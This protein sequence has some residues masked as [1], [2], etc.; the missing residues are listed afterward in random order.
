MQQSE[1]GKGK[2]LALGSFLLILL[3]GFWWHLSASV[4]E[5]YLHIKESQELVNINVY[6]LWVPVGTFG[7]LLYVLCGAFV[8]IKTGVKA[9]Y[10]WGEKGTKFFNSFAGVL[11]IVGLVVAIVLYNWMTNT[12]E[13]NGYIYCKPLSR[14]SA[15]GRHEVYVSKPELCVKRSRE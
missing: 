9:N 12:L 1:I 14:L 2:A 8:T 3:G 10:V 4:F 15:M 6:A 7:L 13:N 5:T 11:V